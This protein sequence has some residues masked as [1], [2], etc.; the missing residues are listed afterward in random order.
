KPDNVLLD[1][2][3][4]PR[5]TD[6]G[7]AR[8]GEATIT[9][10]G[11]V[12]GTYAYL[13]PEALNGEVLDNRADLWA[14]GVMLFEMLAGYRP[15]EGETLTAVVTAILTKP[16]PNLEEQR[17]DAPLALVDLIYRLLEKNREQRIPSARIVGAE[18][19]SILR[20]A[21]TPIRGVL[22]PGLTSPAEVA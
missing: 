19:E 22:S 2:D 12:I 13:C 11:V 16:T 1:D 7:V 4:T 14:F 15:F 17:P 18:I 6:F 10:T 8:I 20:E 3:G 9:R 21:D 5:L